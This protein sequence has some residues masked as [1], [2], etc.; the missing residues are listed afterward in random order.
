MYQTEA[1][2]E[3]WAHAC[4]RSARPE[5][6]TAVAASDTDDEVYFVIYDADDNERLRVHRDPAGHITAS[7]YQDSQS[8]CINSC[9][10]LCSVM[11]TAMQMPLLGT[12]N[13]P[14]LLPL[15]KP[16]P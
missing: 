9:D 10:E 6:A 14:S 8:F 4:A 11:K 15:P 1:D 16:K 7:I 3:R 5:G 13:P 2:L 12:R